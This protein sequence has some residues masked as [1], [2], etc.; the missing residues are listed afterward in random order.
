[1]SI[2]AIIILAILTFMAILTFTAVSADLSRRFNESWPPIDDDEFVSRC[3]PGVNRHVALKVRKIIAEQLG[4]PY[5]Q[6]YPEQR[7]VE[8]LNVD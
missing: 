4:I 3:S 8:D 1:M 5:D 2:L 6:I 7:F